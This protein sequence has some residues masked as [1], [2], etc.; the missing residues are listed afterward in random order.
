MFP[1]GRSPL[2]RFAIPLLVQMLAATSGSAYGLLCIVPHHDKRFESQPL[3]ESM[4]VGTR[5]KVRW[6]EPRAHVSAGSMEFG[7][8][9]CRSF[10]VG[11]FN[12]ER[13]SHKP[14]KAQS[15]LEHK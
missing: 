12:R 9:F 4:K 10:I 3:K 6:L 13:L 15:F 8:A 1:A 5:V 7:P 11:L 14:L 2:I